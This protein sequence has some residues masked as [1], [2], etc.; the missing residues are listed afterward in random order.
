[1][2]NATKEPQKVKKRRVDDGE[3]QGIADLA[4]KVHE[5]ESN[6]KYFIA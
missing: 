6:R 5:M 1:M 2:A 4:E 3:Y